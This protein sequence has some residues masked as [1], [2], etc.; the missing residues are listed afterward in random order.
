[1]NQIFSQDLQVRF[2]DCDPAGIV[3]YP[4]YLE[5][6]NRVV[7]DWCAQA[8]ACSFARMHLEL[9]MGL[10]TVRLQTEFFV[11]SRL[12]DQLRAQLSVCKIGSSSLTVR[13]KLYAQ[14]GVLRV[15][16]E[17]VLVWIELRA[18]RSC[19]LPQEMRQAAGLFLQSDG[20]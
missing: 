16:G 17:L 8:L 11:A 13:I 14:D 10:P 15:A 19:P 18:A 20:Q 9:G 7:E 12:G 6:F 3:F 5:M 4:R 1:M 2:A